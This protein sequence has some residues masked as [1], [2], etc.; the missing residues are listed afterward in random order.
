MRFTE[1]ARAPMEPSYFWAAV[2]FVI[3]L[4][5]T[6]AAFKTQAQAVLDSPWLWGGLGVYIVSVVV[7]QLA[8]Y[9]RQA[10]TWQLLT[11]LAAYTLFIG[12]RLWPHPSA[13]LS[14][15]RDLSGVLVMFVVLS[16]FVDFGRRKGDA[17][18][19]DHL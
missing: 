12:V 1:E 3:V 6:M 13:E 8:R 16:R 10:V 5:C 4:L 15:L 14:R 9:G 19:T 2:A 18:Q 7:L 11:F 17:P